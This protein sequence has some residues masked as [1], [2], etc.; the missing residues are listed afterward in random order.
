MTENEIVYV[1]VCK[2]GTI[3]VKF[4]GCMS[5]EKVDAKGIL[6]TIEHAVQVTGL[7]CNELL[8]KVVVLDFFWIFQWQN[9]VD[10]SDSGLESESDDDE[11]TILK[12]LMN[13]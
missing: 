8:Q 5:T 11:E 2:Q 3:S 4:I 9:Q 12:R 1:R 6:N 7:K 13:Y 10:D